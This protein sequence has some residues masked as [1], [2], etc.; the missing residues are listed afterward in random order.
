MKLLLPAALLLS[1]SACYQ[2]YDRGVA[3]QPVQPMPA[4][5]KRQ[6]VY[7]YLTNRSSGDTLLVA[8]V[9]LVIDDSLVVAED[10]QRSYTGSERLHTV[11]RLCEGMHR[12]HVRF[13]PYTR[14]T[15]FV[16][17][18]DTA[19]SLLAAMLYRNIPELAH[20]DGLAIATLIRD[21]KG[22]HD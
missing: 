20:E 13:G 6:E 17:P 12:V 2:G 14:D 21:G 7:C 3:N 19:I 22:G 18:R 4:P 15:T 16:V 8:P 9:K 11:I 5:C 10:I 1:L